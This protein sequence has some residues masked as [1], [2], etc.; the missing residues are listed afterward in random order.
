MTSVSR[1]LASLVLV[2]AATPVQAGERLLAVDAFSS[3]PVSEPGHKSRPSVTGV[4]FARE[5]VRLG[6]PAFVWMENEAR[7]PGVLRAAPWSP[8]E[9]ARE[10]LE[11]Y[12]R[13]DGLERSD[14]EHAPVSDTLWLRAGGGLITVGQQ[15][16]GVE[17][18]GPSLKVLLDAEQL[19]VAVSGHLSPVASSARYAKGV[20]FR[21]EPRE[22]IAEAYRDLEGHVLPIQ[23]LVETGRAQGRYRS[24]TLSPGPRAVSLARPARAKPIYYATPEVLVPAYYVELSTVP[25]VGAPRGP[26]VYAIA[27]DDGRMLHRHSLSRDV[28]GVSIEEVWADGHVH[29]SSS[30]AADEPVMAAVTHAF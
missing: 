25:V 9:A 13:V 30:S 14:V 11:R 26:H 28:G 5:Q 6:D 18:F 21:L 17:V 7:G 10:V 27:A 3:A 22:A 20:V 12:S 23:G 19:P 16:D 15:V 2:A 24:F 1:L 29:R 8:E 4:S